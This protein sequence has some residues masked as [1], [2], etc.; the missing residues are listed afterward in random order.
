MSE[1]HQPY[2]IRADLLFWLQ[3]IADE[4]F[5]GDLN[6]AL[7]TALMIVRSWNES[8]DD[9]WAAVQTQKALWKRRPR[10]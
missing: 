2:S 5:D 3:D 7:D 4:H 1:R 9:P 6:R 8:P 10:S